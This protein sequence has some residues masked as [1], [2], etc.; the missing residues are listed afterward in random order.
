MGQLTTTTFADWLRPLITSGAR[1]VPGR[2]PDM[3]NRVA[4]ITKSPGP[5]LVMEGLFD[6][7]GL[8]ISC[9]GGENNITDAENIASEID[10]ILIGKHLTIRSENLM[11]GDVF[12]NGLGR[13][14]GGPAQLSMPDSLSRWTFTCNYFAFVSTDVGTVF[15]G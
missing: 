12:V 11:I 9:R 5:G 8:T 3:P 1:V 13:V 15:N 4:G 6:V 7:I 2:I 10:N 14:G